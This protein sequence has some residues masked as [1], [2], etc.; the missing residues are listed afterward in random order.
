V[1]PLEFEMPTIEVRDPTVA[2]WSAWQRM[3]SANCAHQGVA[4]PEVDD[5]ELW[6]RIMDP[7]HAVGALVYCAAEFEGMA[8]GLRTTCS[9]STRSARGWSVTLKTC[10]SNLP[11]AVP[12]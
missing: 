5:R 1:R 10:G 9:I 12:A 3:W 2:D 8:V 4:I 7:D 6:R 11:R